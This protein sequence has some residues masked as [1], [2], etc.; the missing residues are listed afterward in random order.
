MAEY[1]D[2][3]ALLARCKEIA[4]C[5]WN[6]KVASISWADAYESFM[7]EVEQ[8]PTADVVLRGTYE[9]VVF[10][11]DVAM[12]QLKECG[13]PFG[14]KV[15]EPLTLEE[16]RKMD[17]EPVWITFL[18]PTDTCPAHWRIWHN[19]E[20]QESEFKTYGKIWMAYRRKPND[21]ARNGGKHE[22]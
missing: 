1:I 4:Q 3:K 11:R 20:C 21:K 9:Q 8:Q 12:A 13:I 15:N 7:D 6:K 19:H 2:R 16:L 10:E 5:D 14:G 17:G 22:P 18:S